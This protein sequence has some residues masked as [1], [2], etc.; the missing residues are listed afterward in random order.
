MSDVSFK[1]NKTGWREFIKVDNKL[2]DKDF[3]SIFNKSWNFFKHGDNDPDGILD[4]DEKDN[5]HIIF[6]ASLEC[7]ELG[8]SSIEKDVFQL[9]YYAVHNLEANNDIK[10]VTSDFFPSI[11]RLSKN[12]QINF[13]LTVLLNEKQNIL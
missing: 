2:T 6:Y 12:E 4:F 13:G 9:W 10:K 3:K 5:E 7:S 11:Q 8:L 1:K